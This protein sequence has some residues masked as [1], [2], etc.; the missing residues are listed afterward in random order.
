MP[1]VKRFLKES[2]G[3]DQY[4][5]VRIEW[6]PHHNPDLSIYGADGKLEQK[7]DMS[8]YSYEQLHALFAKHF[9]KKAAG[10]A[11]ADAALSSNTTASVATL[12]NDATH[13]HPDH[14]GRAGADHSAG[15]PEAARPPLGAAT[16]MAL[17]ALL[18]VAAL[19]LFRSGRN[20]RRRRAAA[21]LLAAQGSEADGNVD[22]DGMC[23]VA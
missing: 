13:P 1:K 10:R 9:I 5:G 4:D 6:I 16:H 19:L 20:A 11:L 8:T 2:G 15:T 7:I 22:R 14:L 23:H 3:I 12:Q 18:V 17:L 21:K